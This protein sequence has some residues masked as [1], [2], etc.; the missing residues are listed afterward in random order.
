MGETKESE[1]IWDGWWGIAEPLNK[2]IVWIS[3]GLVVLGWLVGS[4]FYGP[5]LIWNLWRLIV[6]IVGCIL[7]LI[8]VMKPLAD[9]DLNAK[10]H[11]FL[12]VAVVCCEI[13]SYWAGLVMIFQFVLV[14][15]LS[16][17]PI[18]KAFSE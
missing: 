13:A 16:D 10:V 9:K 2:F 4:L 1:A 14:S 8:F 3:I 15:I 7:Y 6:G 11:I 12:I 17:K 18:W 5:L